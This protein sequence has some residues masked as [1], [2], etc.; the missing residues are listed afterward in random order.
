MHTQRTISDYSL[1]RRPSVL[2]MLATTI[3]YVLLGS[4]GLVLAI[5]PGYASPVFPAAG[6][7]IALTLYFGPIILPAIWLG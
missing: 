2:L 6:L 3:G 5:P 1:D 7:S 4:A